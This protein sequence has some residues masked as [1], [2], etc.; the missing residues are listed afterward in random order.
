M[1][2][3]RDNTSVGEI[4]RDGEKIVVIERANYPESFALPAGHVDGDP[5]FISAV[6][7]ELEEEVGLRVDKNNIV[8]EEDIDN[9]CKREGGTHHLWKV[10]EA[11]NWS[12]ELRA[13]SDAKKAVWFSKDDL[14]KIAA[15]TEYFM[16]KYGI[17]YDKV[18][19]LTVAIFGKN[20]AEKA[21]DQEWKQEM[22]LEP[23]WY[24]ILKKLGLI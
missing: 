19:K 14:Q 7:R 21:T 20:P 9:P 22:G 11:L 18:G 17:S 1:A 15:R 23:V 2:K 24:Y 16:K 6:T 4:I 3:I 10:Y 8:F 13:G 12:G 5:N